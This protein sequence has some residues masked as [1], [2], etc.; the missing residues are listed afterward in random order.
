LNKIPL[1]VIATAVA[2][3]SALGRPCDDE[4]Q[5]TTEFGSY[6]VWGMDL[7]PSRGST[8][9]EDPDT[10]LIQV[11]LQRT[12][13]ASG[14]W[15]LTIRDHTG[16][17]LQSVSSQ[18]ITSDAPFWSNRLPTNLLE[19][20]VKA[21]SG[22]A[23][24]RG[25]EYV[26]VSKI[27]KRP[28]Y[29]IQGAGPVWTDLFTGSAVPRL[30]RRIGDSVGMFIG[31]E[32]NSVQGMSL[33]TC[34][35]FVISEDPAVLFVTNDHCGG[36]W[37][38]SSDR[39]TDGVCSNATVDFSW[40]GDSVSREYACKDVV[41]RSADD[42]IA[43][44]RL[45]PLKQDAAPPALVIRTQPLSDETVSIIHHPAANT[46]QVSMNCTA[47]TDAIANVGTVDLS[48][49]FAH[50]CDTE[51]GSSG[52]PVLD[53]TGRVV[54]IHHLGFKRPAPNACDFLNKA[55]QAGK[56]IDLLRS[57]PKLA[58]YHYRFD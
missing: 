1:I 55:V 20:D 28:Y 9:D 15:A 42:D 8:L 22:T 26:T 46:K 34:T 18:Q 6:K 4:T 25:V 27:A 21:D 43:I 35:G 19:F 51:G 38:V 24:I 36:N 45:E 39:W 40:D 7:G 37:A 47:I 41:G 12:P 48:R 5:I 57:D 17:P 13:T 50:R 32:G 33:W 56:L 58:G 2:T 49:D 31:H 54:G 53:T 23:P 29:S 10:R 16:R 30:Y 3:T 44:L 52:A 14:T 11:L